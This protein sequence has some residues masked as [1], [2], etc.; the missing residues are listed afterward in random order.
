MMVK[1]NILR[2]LFLFCCV[3]FGFA[4][5]KTWSL[6]EC[7]QY[8]IDHNLEVKQQ[9]FA[10]EDAKLTTSN[11]KGSFLPNLNVSARN[12]WNNGLSQNVTTGVL[13]NQTT[14]N[15][16]YGVSSSIPIYN[17][18]QN[19]YTLQQSKLQEIAAQ[20]N[21]EKV[22]DDMM[23][24]VANAYLEVLL[25]QENIAILKAQNSLTKEQLNLAKQQVDAGTLAQGEVLQLEATAANDLQKIAEAENS[26]VIS[27]LSLKRLLNM[28]V[29]DE[30][31]LKEVEIGLLDRKRLETPV[32]EI[33]EK[34]MSNRNE[35]KL[36]EINIDIAKKGVDIAKGAYLPTLSGFINFDTRETDI[37]DLGYF[38]QLK[39]NYGFVYG[40]SLSIPV[41]NRFQ[42]KN[43]VAKSKINVLKS[44][45]SLKQTQQKVTQD[46]YQAYLNAKAM[47][48][49][50]EASQKNTEAQKLAFEYQETRFDVG[51]SNLLDYTQSKINY[52]NSQT[53]LL[54]VKY[55]LLFR[56]KI[57]DLYYGLN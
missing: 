19:Y 6:E 29:T 8:A 14:R 56:L 49:T 24:N 37:F 15:S 40:F 9:L 36:S 18:F 22:K 2:V 52:Q 21:I 57:L 32:D 23:L 39:N 12:S 27:K 28:E 13:I 3:Q 11:A 20:F 54:R 30:M 48:K 41:F 10:L 45:N 42:T 7:I 1:K 46:V 43:A 51:Q 25:Q 53:E 38:D 35:I 5:T 31:E 4:Q 33:V 17:G 50:F 26:L 34:V 16:S 47:Y 44:E 55:N